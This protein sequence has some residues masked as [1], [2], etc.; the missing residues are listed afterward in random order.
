MNKPSMNEITTHD[1][2]QS[3]LN[4]GVREFIV[5]A[6]QRNSSFVEALRL[7]EQIKVYYWPEERSAAFFALGRS[8]LTKQPTA[9]VVTSGTACG[10][11]LPAVMNAHYLSV[12]LL[13]IT[14]DRPPSFRGSGAPQAAEQVDLFKQYVQFSQDLY[15][16]IPCTL[17]K[18]HK[19]GAAHL[20][21]CLK[22]PQRY[23]YL[24]KNPFIIDTNTDTHQTQQIDHTHS[25]S[26]LDN[27]FNRVKNPLVIVSTLASEAISVLVPFLKRLN[28]PLFL[29]GISGIREE[30]SLQHLRIHRTDQILES[31]QRCGYD[32]DGVLRIGGVPTHRIW[33]DLE[34]LQDKVAVYNITDTPF[35]GLSWNR[36]VIHA[37]IQSVLQSYGVKKQYAAKNASTWLHEE[38]I[39]KSKLLALFENEPLSEPALIHQLSKIIPSN[40]H[41]YL[42]NS[43]PVREWDLAASDAAK[44]LCITASRGLN[45]IDGQI[46]TF[47]GLCKPQCDNWAILGDL[48]TIYDM[49]GFWILPQLRPIKSTTVVINNGGGKLF[50]TF[51]P[52]K[53]MLNCHDL[54][55]KP[56]ADMWRLDYSKWTTIPE[57]EMTSS[58][59]LQ[60]RLIEI[61]PDDTSTQRFKEKYNKMQLSL[62][63][64]ASRRLT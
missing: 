19:T 31:A 55:F 17:S 25:H 20:N 1:V 15:E 64:N 46:S 58:N 38:V 21:V 47:L 10:E 23:P 27:F 14:A 6:G 2:I 62:L 40:S 29:E 32:I 33:R 41:L 56:L 5:C 12:P 22:E 63:Q 61:I 26:E 30:P 59:T 4:C 28:A 16:N 39:F 43:L 44:N 18:W 3:A 54:N 9:V 42:G 51:S 8:R 53:E 48:T 35:S 49:A 13:V 36:S 52:H 7:D 57:T 37:P 34:Y 60:H 11:L 45:G 24:G 50:E